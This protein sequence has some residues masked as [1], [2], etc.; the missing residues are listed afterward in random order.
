[1][2]ENDWYALCDNISRLDG[3]YYM[4]QSYYSAFFYCNGKSY[5]IIRPSKTEYSPD[6][7]EV[8]TTDSDDN[9]KLYWVTSSE[10]LFKILKEEGP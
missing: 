7:I 9:Y 2:S 6:V 10:E 8:E 5:H 1:M 4:I 3:I